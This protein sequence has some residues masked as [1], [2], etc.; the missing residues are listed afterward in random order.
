MRAKR[1][2]VG[3]LERAA[4]VRMRVTAAPPAGVVR[5]CPPTDRCTWCR[6]RI[7]AGSLVRPS[8]LDWVIMRLLAGLEHMKHHASEPALSGLVTMAECCDRARLTRQQTQ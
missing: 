6:R 7:N 2:H 3:L 4:L 8:L 5:M 1:R